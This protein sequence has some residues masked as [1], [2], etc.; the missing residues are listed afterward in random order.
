MMRVA[1]IS[2]ANSPLELVGREIPE[3]GPNAVRVAVDACAG[4]RSGGSGL[5]AENGDSVAW[6]F[7]RPMRDAVTEEFGR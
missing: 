7:M 5:G 1:Q 4:G 6:A 3:P 2:R